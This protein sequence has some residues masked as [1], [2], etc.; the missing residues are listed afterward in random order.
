MPAFRAGMTLALELPEAIGSGPGED[1][2]VSADLLLADW[3][4]VVSRVV[5]ASARNLGVGGSQITPGAGGNP[6]GLLGDC[7]ALVL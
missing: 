2:A 3:S 4:L 5:S 1:E 7:W 6:T